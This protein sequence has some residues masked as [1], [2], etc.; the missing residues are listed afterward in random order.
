VR[1]PI[2]I[3][4]GHVT[5]AAPVHDVVIHTLALPGPPRVAASVAAPA[6]DDVR[7]LAWSP[8]RTCLAVGT[9][10]AVVLYAAI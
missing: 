8:D 6:D 10:S 3:A 5:M 4:R 2:A 7:C 9:S 1:P